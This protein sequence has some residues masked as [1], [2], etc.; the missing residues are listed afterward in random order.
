MFITTDENMKSSKYS[1]DE[2]WKF[3]VIKAT[4]EYM[5]ILPENLIRALNTVQEYWWN[6]IK[7]EAIDN[8]KERN[9]LHYAKWECYKKYLKHMSSLQS[10]EKM[11]LKKWKELFKNTLQNIK[12]NSRFVIYTE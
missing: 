3:Y 8:W 2:G 5:K 4:R 1:Y 11:Q 12:S 6:L 10:L 7:L 9:L